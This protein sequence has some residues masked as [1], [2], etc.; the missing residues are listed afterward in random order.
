M[1]I[2]LLG[3][4]LAGIVAMQVEVLKLGA[5][6][7]RSINRTTTLQVR[8]EALR[9]SVAQLADDQRIELLAARQGMIMPAPANVAFLPAVGGATVARAIAA[10][11]APAPATFLT[12]TTANG[13]VTTGANSLST[14]PTAPA[15]TAGAG[16][17]A[18]GTTAGVT[19]S[20]AGATIP[21]VAST[22]STS[23]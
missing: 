5:S 2:A 6:M 23:H 17:T 22:S 18:S 20:G 10:I 19:T 11:H 3:M 21:T 12:T 9:A 14:D 7:G 13:A 4:M 8:N 1:W 16:S 15:T